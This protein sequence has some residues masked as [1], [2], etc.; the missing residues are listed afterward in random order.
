MT[1][2]SELDEYLTEKRILVISAPSLSDP[3]NRAQAADLL[4][5][6]KG[7]VEREL[8]VQTRL[9]FFKASPRHSSSCVLFLGLFKLRGR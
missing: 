8:V 5:K 4:S 3:L 7:L 1:L 2:A 6:W 9:I